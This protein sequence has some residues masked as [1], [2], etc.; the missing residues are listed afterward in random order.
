MVC[1][2]VLPLLTS[3]RPV[4]YSLQPGGPPGHPWSEAL[5]WPLNRVQ[6]CLQP[7]MYRGDRHPH[8]DGGC[9]E[10]MEARER[11]GGARYGYAVAR[12]GLLD[13]T[14]YCL[15]AVYFALKHRKEEAPK[16]PRAVEALLRFGR[17]DPDPGNF[18]C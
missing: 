12:R 4:V 13:A 17:C 11:H 1:S 16:A 8:G 10:W 3:M 5:H 7:D 2:Y 14:S 9:Q 15:N 6:H 18:M